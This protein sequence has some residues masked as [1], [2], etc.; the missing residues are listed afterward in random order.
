VDVSLQ[1]I[2]KKYN[3]E[4]IFRGV[5]YQFTSNS[6]TAVI[7]NN[8]SGKSTLLQLIATFSDATLGT[9][10]Y[11]EVLP[12]HRISYV[13]PYLELIEELTLLEHLNFHFQFKKATCSFDHMIT[14]VGLQGAEYKQ[15]AN[16][17]SGMKQRLKLALAVFSEDSLL[18]L[19]EPCSNLDEEGIAWYQAQLSAIIGTKTIIIASNQRFEYEFCQKTLDITQYKNRGK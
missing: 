2:G 4:W 17:S 19:D 18:L 9:I 8:G 10:Q 11:S 16:F 3:K 12:Q 14:T 6:A 15:I 7:G 13:A 1:G 5:D